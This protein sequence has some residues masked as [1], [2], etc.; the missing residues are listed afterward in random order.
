MADP[1]ESLVAARARVAKKNAAPASVF[2]GST[3]Y[4]LPDGG[5]VVTTADGRVMYADQNNQLMMLKDPTGE[6][7]PK[8]PITEGAIAD[9]WAEWSKIGTIGEAVEK[10]IQFKDSTKDMVNQ[11]EDD[12]AA[13]F[14]IMDPRFNGNMGDSD[15][16]EATAAA[17]RMNSGPTASDREPERAVDAQGN[18]RRAFVSTTDRAKEIA[19]KHAK[20]KDGNPIDTGD[21]SYGGGYASAEGE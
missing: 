6:F 19:A 1:N 14:E 18:A 21:T 7:K 17:K 4:E 11:S 9:E 12:Y 20:D 13:Q 5:K 3:S 10:E 16:G 2:G 15:L 8:Q